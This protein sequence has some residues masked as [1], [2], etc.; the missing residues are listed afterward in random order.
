MR[1][2]TILLIFF[3]LDAN[4]W[5]ESWAPTFKS[6]PAKYRKLS[7]QSVANY[8]CAAWG[9]EDEGSIRLE[10]SQG[11]ALD[12]NGDKVEDY[13]FIVPW[14]GNGLNAYGHN[15]YFVVSDGE[16]GWKE[17]VMECYGANISDLV[18]VD[19]KPYFRVSNFYENFEKSI[20]NHWVYQ[21]LSFGKNGTVKCANAELGKPF[22][23][24][25]IFYNNP[26]FKQIE[27]TA[28]DLKKIAA[29]LKPK[30]SKPQSKALLQRCMR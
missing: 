30:P 13:V 1:F 29:E 15:V 26:K 2:L 24:V 28:G 3:A 19:D 22:P 25:T 11:G 14:V 16:G 20:H 23:A 10:Y 9:E 18:T 4:A 6:T 21:I 5:M 27:L 17:S 12:L 7:A 8:V